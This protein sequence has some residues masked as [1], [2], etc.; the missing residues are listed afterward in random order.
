M[1]GYADLVKD[2]KLRTFFQTMITE[3][4]ELTGKMIDE[5]FGSP[6]A[7]RRPR[8]LRTL[9]TREFSLYLL[10][11]QQIRLLSEWREAMQGD[12]EEKTAALLNSLQFSV[13]AIASGL[14]TTG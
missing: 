10:H 1:N 7:E 3:E 12:D 9:E 11:Q 13:N 8:M 2:K 5:V 14:R 4:F 6:F